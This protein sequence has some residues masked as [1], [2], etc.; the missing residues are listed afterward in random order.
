MSAMGCVF[1]RGDNPLNP[2]DLDVILQTQTPLS[3]DRVGA[4]CGDRIA[5]GQQ[6]GVS[7]PASS[8]EPLPWRDD[9]AGLT[10]AAD[11]R[12]DN[13]DDL[14][15]TLAVP[16]DQRQTLSDRQLLL[17]AYQKWGMD[18]PDH[19]IGDFAFVIWD[20]AEQRVFGARDVAGVRP[21]YYHLSPQRLVVASDMLA[22]MA[23]PNMPQ[24]LDDIYVGEQNLTILFY[25]N[26]PIE[27]TIYA[28]VRR[29]PPAH[30]MVVSADKCRIWQWWS[31]D[32]AP[33]V[34]GRSVVAYAEE[35]RALLH[36]AVT[37]RLRS[38][39]PVG[40][41]LSGGL[42]SSSVAVTAAR[43]LQDCGQT[44]PVFFWAPRGDSNP[45]QFDDE[46]AWVDD[47]CQ[48]E[49]LTCHYPD[50][51]VWDAATW[52]LRS[53]GDRYAGLSYRERAVHRL[54][55]A[56]SVGVMLSGLGGSRSISFFCLSLWL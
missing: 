55:Q 30:A 44:L 3:I 11:V 29:L 42:D 19:L 39:V 26:P 56:K 21:F 2:H 41:H 46:R 48:R 45:Y 35:L 25:S 54:A 23:L 40:A 6:T 38:A 8:Q 14:C 16:P 36:Q 10:I 13:R 32:Q 27:A 53:A 22:L 50:V 31:P 37:C 12:L 15:A 17:C 18:C 5:L 28:A 1:H 43:A 9:A 4:W 24:E 52:R 33:D 34:R 7:M 51:T 47:I 49:N 20:A